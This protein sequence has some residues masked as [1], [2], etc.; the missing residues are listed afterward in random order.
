MDYKLQASRSEYVSTYRCRPVLRG[1]CGLQDHP[2]LPIPQE[3]DFGPSVPPH[4]SS[5]GQVMQ[6]AGIGSTRCGY[7]MES[8]DDD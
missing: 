6:G 4:Q 1:A 2:P 8:M 5:S 7:N 3:R